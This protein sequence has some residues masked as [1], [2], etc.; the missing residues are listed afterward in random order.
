MA[1][2]PIEE[3]TKPAVESC[4]SRSQGTAMNIRL[5]REDCVSQTQFLP[6][7]PAL[8][9]RSCRPSGCLCPNRWPSALPRI[10]H[11]NA[12]QAPAYAAVNARRTFCP[13]ARPDRSTRQSDGVSPGPV[14]SPRPTPRQAGQSRPLPQELGFK[15]ATQAPEP[16]A[17]IVVPSVGQAPGRHFWAQLQ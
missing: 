8:Q 2:I 12:N 16:R 15:R 1:G 4:Q 3:S 9:E 13:T 6:S 14:A 10:S 17:V 5:S 11:M 7:Q